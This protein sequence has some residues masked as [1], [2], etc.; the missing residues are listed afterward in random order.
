[1]IYANSKVNKS[2]LGH[3][4]NVSIFNFLWALLWFYF[5]VKLS[6]LAFANLVLF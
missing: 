6:F 3:F 1:M 5:L 2:I 4:G